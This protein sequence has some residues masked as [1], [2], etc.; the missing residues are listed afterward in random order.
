M[1]AQL[2]DGKSASDVIGDPNWVQLYRGVFTGVTIDLGEEM[3]VSGYEMGQLSWLGAGVY[4]SRY[5]EF[6]VSMDGETFYL[7]HRWE[8]QKMISKHAE[9]A[10]R[11]FL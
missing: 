8:D 5:I 6:S 10:R 11:P 2:T 3:A 4:L 7:V 9:R 1:L